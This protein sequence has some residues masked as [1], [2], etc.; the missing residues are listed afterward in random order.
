LKLRGGGII[1][2][3]TDRFK[4]VHQGLDEEILTISH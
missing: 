2:G 1:H 4:V 3:T